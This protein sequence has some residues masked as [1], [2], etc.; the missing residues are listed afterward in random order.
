MTALSKI[1]DIIPGFMQT[2]SGATIHPSDPHPDSIHIEDIANALA[3]QCRYAG[4]CLKFYSV[5]EHCCHVSDRATTVYKLSALMHDASEAY[6]VDIPR[7]VKPL[8]QNYYA[9][10]DKLMRIIAKKY[11]FDWPVPDEVKYLDTA[12]LTDEREQNMA[13]MEVD[14]KAWGSPYPALGVTLQYWEPE[15]AAGQ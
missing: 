14:G 1:S 13:K 2:F 4:H 10:E 8:L 11:N 6:L 12:I 15:K 5:A 7:P 9:V 3:R